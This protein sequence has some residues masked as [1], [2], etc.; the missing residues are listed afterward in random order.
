MSRLLNEQIQLPSLSPPFGADTVMVG[1]TAGLIVKIVSLSSNRRA[2]DTSLINTR[3]FVDVVFGIVQAYEPALALTFVI[4]IQLVPLFVLYCN[5][6]FETLLLV[7][8]IFL[9]VPTGQFSPP[10]G[11]VTSIDVSGAQVYKYL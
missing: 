1:V 2:F 3:Q 8:V 6:T 7:Q 4:F 5:F 11:A 10:F 9:T